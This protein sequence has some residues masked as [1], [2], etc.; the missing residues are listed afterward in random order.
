MTEPAITHVPTPIEPPNGES[1]CDSEQETH[2]EERVAPTGR[3]ENGKAEG[4]DAFWQSYPK[5]IAP[6]EAQ[7]AYPAGHWPR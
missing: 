3:P 2:E 6:A 4:F 1:V 7:E 5:H